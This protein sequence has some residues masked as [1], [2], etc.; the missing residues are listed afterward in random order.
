MDYHHAHVRGSRPGET[1]GGSNLTLMTSTASIRD[2][3]LLV[4][5]SIAAT[6]HIHHDCT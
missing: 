3:K 4:V 6:H 2:S 1:G 5:P